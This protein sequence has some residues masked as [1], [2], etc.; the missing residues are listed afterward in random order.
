MELFTGLNTESNITVI[1]VTHENDIAAY[2][3]RII[4][5]LDG[6]IVIDEKTE[7]SPKALPSGERR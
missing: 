5:F 3:K 4:K 2:S 1:L 6:R 7:H